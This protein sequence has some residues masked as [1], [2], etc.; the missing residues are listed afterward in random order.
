MSLDDWHT[1]KPHLARPWSNTSAE[2]TW[3][4]LEPATDDWPT[5]EPVTDDWPDPE[6]A[7]SE[8]VDILDQ[9]AG[10]PGPLGC[11]C[12]AAMVIITGEHLKDCEIQ[13]G[14]E[15]DDHG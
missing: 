11:G 8:S 1:P 13:H 6:P 10:I 12:D 15:A 2:E 14:A 7:T 4:D 5:P 9:R 3:P